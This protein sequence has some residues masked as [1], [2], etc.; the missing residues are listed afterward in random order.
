LPGRKLAGIGFRKNPKSMHFKDP[1]IRLGRIPREEGKV[2]TTVRKENY[3]VWRDYFYRKV[4]ETRKE[5]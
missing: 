4:L 2:G 1:F 5:D 3:D